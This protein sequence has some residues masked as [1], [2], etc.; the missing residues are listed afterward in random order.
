MERGARTSDADRL[1]PLAVAPAPIY[2]KWASVY[3]RF[4]REAALETWRRGVV[5]EI[6]RLG[7]RPG[8]R[9]LDLGAGTGIGRRVLLEEVRGARVVC[10][11]QSI[12]MLEA[13]GVPSDLRVV[14]NMAAFA[15]DERF[16][17]VVSGFDAL[18]YLG[19]AD[20]ATC[21]ASVASVLRDD[22][23][24]VFD[25][26]SRR[27]LKYEWGD[28][29][30]VSLADGMALERKHLYEP[31]ADRTRIDL[32]LVKDGRVDW[33]ETHYHQSVDPYTIDELAEAAGLALVRVRDVDS[34][35]FSPGAPT[36]VYMLR[37]ADAP[38]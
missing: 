37:K 35:T 38:A 21:F 2:G 25:Y 20:L 29:A 6:R 13:G 1:A 15:L 12:A 31:E 26:S 19:V 3:E 22:G 4:E 30:Y 18:N 23:W 24:L 7:A 34:E 27:L 8:A 16:D 11:D 28:L 32:R 9:I 36:H 5:V 14:T 33:E 10:L 17:F